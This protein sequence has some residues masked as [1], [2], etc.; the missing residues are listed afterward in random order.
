MDWVSD[1]RSKAFT[2]QRWIGWQRWTGRRVYSSQVPHMG[3][4]V[5]RRTRLEY[6]IQVDKYE[7]EFLNF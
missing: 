4:T 5:S 7:P 6:S 3:A 1:T 2:A